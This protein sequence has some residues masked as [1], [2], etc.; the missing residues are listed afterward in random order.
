M[1]L[2]RH[3]PDRRPNHLKFRTPFGFSLSIQAGSFIIRCED[4]GREFQSDWT[5]GSGCA[6]KSVRAFPMIVQDAAIWWEYGDGQ[7]GEG[8]ATYGTY[9]EWLEEILEAF[10]PEVLERAL[11]EE[12]FL[13]EVRLARN[14]PHVDLPV[15]FTP[16]EEVVDSLDPRV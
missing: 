16:G 5:C 12:Q 3:E 9:E 11:I 7:S 15:L 4:H 6:K 13:N 8:S 14:S 10:V 2:L 1:R